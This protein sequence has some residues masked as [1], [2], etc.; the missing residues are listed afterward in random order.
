MLTKD[1][2]K[3]IGWKELFERELSGFDLSNK[4]NLFN[5]TNRIQT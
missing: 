1:A 5:L 4:I 3:R 2:N